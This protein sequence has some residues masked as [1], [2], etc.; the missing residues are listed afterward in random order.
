MTKLKV[1]KTVE[2]VSSYGLMD[3]HTHKAIFFSVMCRFVTLKDAVEYAKKHGYA[4][5][6]SIVIGSKVVK[7]DPTQFLVSKEERKKVLLD[8]D[9]AEN[10]IKKVSQRQGFNIHPPVKKEKSK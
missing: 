4:L 7:F 8:I 2:H 6:H 9:I 10:G 3:A 5:D 1:F